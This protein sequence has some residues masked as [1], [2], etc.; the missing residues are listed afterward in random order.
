MA[1]ADYWV[2][3]IE[4]LH[5]LEIMVPFMA[6]LTDT[7]EARMSVSKLMDLPRLKAIVDGRMTIEDGRKVSDSGWMPCD[8]TPGTR[9]VQVTKVREHVCKMYHLIWKIADETDLSEEPVTTYLQEA[10]DTVSELWVAANGLGD[11]NSLKDEAVA[12]FYSRKIRR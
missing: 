9:A 2:E 1:L 12:P 4:D 7:H 10:L 6:R 3:V 5:N 8:E 11:H